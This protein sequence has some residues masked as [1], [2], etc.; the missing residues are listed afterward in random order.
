MNKGF[1]FIELLLV[2][3]ITLIIGS[4]SA[5]FFSRFISQN[6]VSNTQDQLTNQLRKAQLYAMM[7]KQNSNWGVNFSSNTI[8]LYQGNSFAARNTAFDEVFTVNNSVT[9][10]GLSDTN[11]ARMTGIPNTTSSV[12]VS[13]TGGSKTIT[14]NSQGVVN[15]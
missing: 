6:A 9:V 10:S 4:Y 11:F 15:K 13:G 5:V 12:T 8:T 7:S 1:T 3:S 14:V 2:I